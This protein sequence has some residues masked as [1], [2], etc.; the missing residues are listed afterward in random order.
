MF[1]SV[2]VLL[3]EQNGV[4]AIPSSSINYAPYGDSVFVISDQVAEKDK[5]LL[6]GPDGKPY[7]VVKEQFVKLGPTRGDQV[8][9]L[10]GLKAGDEVVSSGVFR[11]RNA[12]PIRVENMVQP[13]NETNPR[14]PET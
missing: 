1:A 6:C 14:P 12:S 5:P 13:S 7:K 10:S 9:V 11:L 4:L 2:E 8:S 3:P